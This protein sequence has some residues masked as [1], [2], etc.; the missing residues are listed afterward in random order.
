MKTILKILFLS[1]IIGVIAFG[2]GKEKIKPQHNANITLYNKPLS[3]IQQ[4]ITGDWNLQYAVGGIAGGKYVDTT[5][6]YWNLTPNH[7]IAGNDISGIYV[8]TTIIWTPRIL[9]GEK[10]YLLSYPSAP[11]YYIVVR[12]KHDTLIIRDY[13]DDG[14]AYFFTKIE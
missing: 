8:D 5:H 11:F 6:T 3:I 9:H 10:T 12:I 7:I 13:A 2:C 4:Y 1:G 14:Y